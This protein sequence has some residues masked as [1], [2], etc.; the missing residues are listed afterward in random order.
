M[1]GSEPQPVPTPAP[2]P[3]GPVET[4]PTIPQPGG[5]NIQT[6]EPRDS[7][8]SVKVKFPQSR[9]TTKV[10]DAIKRGG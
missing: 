2:P 3:A 6:D 8:E 5:V 7:T 4:G 1:S 10:G 9:G